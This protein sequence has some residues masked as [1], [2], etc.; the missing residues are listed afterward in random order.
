M[1][2]VSLHIGPSLTTAWQN[3]ALPWFEAAA[4]ISWRQEQP[5]LV[6]IPFRSHA[7]AIKA[8]L[9]DR[10]LSVLGI[11]FVTPPA[12]RELLAVKNEMQ[13]PLREHLRLILAIAAEESMKLPEDPAKR[14]RR[15]LEADFLAAKSVARAPDHL[16]R[17]IDQL[18]AAGW[19]FSA[20]ELPALREIAA[21]FQERLAK[22]GFELI[23]TADRRAL[24]RAADRPP[25]F[26]NILLTGFNGAHWPLWPLLRAAVSSAEEATVLLEDPRDEDR[27]IDEKWV[28]TW[29]EAFGEATPISSSASRG[30]DT[31]FSEEEMRGASVSRV[32][33][34]FLVGAN[35]TEQAEAVAQQCLH[36]LAD[37]ECDRVGIVFSGA[38]SLPRLVANALTRLEIPHHDGIAHV[39]PGRFEAADWRAWLE[40]QQG[41][42]INSLLH[43]VNALPQRGELLSDLSPTIF[44]RTL[45]SAYAE[46]LID[47]L[48][49]LKQFC[50]QEP[51]DNRKSVAKILDSIP[52]L[53]ARARL[54]EFL[55]ATRAALDRLGWKS[56]W[57]EISQR[58]GDWIDKLDVEFSRALYL[59]WLGEIA[60]T[61]TA[62]REP[63][64]DH[65]YARVQLLTVPQTPAQRW[66]HLIFAGWNEGSWP[67]REIGEFAR[68]DEID[69]F[70]RS[71]EKL[72]RR[73]ARR[74][75]QG[76]GHVA[77]KENH[78]LYLGPTERRQIALRQFGALIESATKKIAFTASLVQEDAPERLWNPSELF[79]QHYQ[80]AHH[81]PL[82]HKAMSELQARTRSW[83]DESREDKKPDASSLPDTKPTRIAYD[84]RRDPSVRSGEYDFAFRSKP[85]LVPTLSVSEFEQLIATPA[86]VWLRKYLGVK[87][88]DESANVWNTSTGKWVHDWLVAIAAG[89]AQTF[90][91]LPDV[92]EIE[93]RVCAAAGAKRSDVTRLCEA[94]GK[95]IP[96]WWSGGWRNALFLARALADK[97]TTVADWPW[98]ATEWTVEGDFAVETADKVV[99]LLRG[100]ID[101]LLARAEPAAGS[102]DT[103]ELW[104]VDYKTGAKRALTRARQDADGRRPALKKK[105]LDGSALQLGLYALA[106]HAFGA[107]QTDVSLLSPLVRPF[108]PQMSGADFLSEADIFADLAEMQQ[109]GVFGMHGPLRSAYRFTDDYPL[110]T[111]AVDP[112]ILEQRWELTHP[113]LV[114]D[115]EDIFW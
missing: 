100:R 115:E 73:A 6:G 16:L 76:E 21:L 39:V 40:L 112:D 75:R 2:R 98:M 18:G 4:R 19:D 108:Q 96:D 78:T 28:G 84:A 109:T 102:L 35:T 46:V 65:P 43:F 63:A 60:S 71:I 111:L 47:D 83:L 33:R 79:T 45:R 30:T 91:R 27:D 34:S 14:E 58:V 80:E 97:L 1:R 51:G 99:L 106:A 50:A 11:R 44:E 69:A 22:C 107:R 54:P 20:V 110:A 92:A 93:R 113:A 94:A 57:M 95:P 36:F 62:A 29:E 90:T 37:P 88:A 55:K 38:G 56:H 9:L 61:F 53:P 42:R 31:L 41:P 12:M 72:N 59:R 81:R 103:D 77:I 5:T 70:N 49:I 26:A 24:E 48:Q 104:I 17:T 85:T 32:S 52:F 25:S 8:L 67:P 10:G 66:S 68:Q 101:L 23:H 87:A 105:L 64:G 74:G 15:M 7:Y 86:L 89:P 3:I 82:T 13:L 114:R